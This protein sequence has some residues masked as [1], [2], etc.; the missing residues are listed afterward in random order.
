MKLIRIPLLIFFF[1]HLAASLSES[2]FELS[3]YG[4][5]YY[6]ISDPLI[7]FRIVCPL[8]TTQWFG[9]GISPTGRMI[10]SDIF[11]GYLLPDGTVY[12]NRYMAISYSPPV[13]VQ[14]SWNDSTVNVIKKSI[15]LDL[16]HLEN[17]Y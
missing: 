6:S 12:I 4:K 15:K 8:S 1:I 10:G 11:M 16:I 17:K 13:L 5:V 3:N 2:S 7:S 9:F 14:P